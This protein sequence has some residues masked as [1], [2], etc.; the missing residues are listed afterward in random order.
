ATLLGAQEIGAAESLASL[1]TTPLI[2]T[3]P[4]LVTR[5]EYAIVSPASVMPLP[6]TST[7]AAAVFTRVSAGAGV[8]VGVDVVAGS[9][10]TGVPPGGV[11]VAVALLSTLPAVSSA[12]V[13][14]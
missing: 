8:L 4:A 13:M 14:M 3:L 6:L 10:V 9:L 7:G 1:M 12:G 5:N 11:P 2:G